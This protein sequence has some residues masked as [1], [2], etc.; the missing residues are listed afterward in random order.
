[1]ATVLN[2]IDI[3]GFD[4]GNPGDPVAFVSMNGLTF[5]AG[6]QALLDFIN[7]VEALVATQQ[8]VDS[9]TVTKFETVSTQ[10]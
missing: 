5:Q 9:T 6:A 4:S 1:M 7:D 8:N 10:I 3:A 2:F